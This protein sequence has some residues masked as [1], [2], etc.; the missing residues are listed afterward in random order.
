[1]EFEVRCYRLLEQST[2][3]QVKVDTVENVVYKSIALER[4]LYTTFCR[5]LHT[6]KAFTLMSYLFYTLSLYSSHCTIWST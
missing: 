6:M 4:D 2:E 5:Y 3:Y 1:M